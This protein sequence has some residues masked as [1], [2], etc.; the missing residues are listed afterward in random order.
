M[1]ANFR[2]EIEFPGEHIVDFLIFWNT[3]YVNR[4]S[5]RR[6]QFG[7][8]PNPDGR[9][10]S[11]VNLRSDQLS[12]TI[13]N[14]MY[15]S[16]ISRFFGPDICRKIAGLTGFGLR[17]CYFSIVQAEILNFLSFQI[18][19]TYGHSCQKD[20][21]WYWISFNPVSRSTN[22][23]TLTFWRKGQQ[24]RI[25]RCPYPGLLGVANPQGGLLCSLNSEK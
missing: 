21:F 8:Q 17:L 2:C 15:V 5:V 7:I 6:L 13:Q 25:R 18:H 24:C 4:N 19:R 14:C 11:G 9:C 23:I 16:D 20:L 1:R 10:R 12:E 3:F 22:I